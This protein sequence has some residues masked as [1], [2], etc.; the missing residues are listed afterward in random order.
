MTMKK[1]ILAFAL[2][3]VISLLQ[4]NMAFGIDWE[5]WRI[6]D[7]W[8]QDNFG[9]KRSP[10]DNTAYLEQQAAHAAA[11]AKKKQ[12]MKKQQQEA[13]K[14]QAMEQWK[15]LQKKLEKQV[16]EAEAQKKKR[17]QEVLKKIGGIGKGGKLEPFK[18]GTTAL[19]AQPIGTQEQVKFDATWMEK[20]KQLIEQRNS[21]V[22]DKY[23]SLKTKVPLRPLGIKE[24]LNELQAGDVLLIDAVGPQRAVSATDN[25]FSGGKE[26]TSSHTVSYLKEVNG[27]KLFMDNQPGAGPRIISEDEFLKEYG[28]RGIKAARLKEKP[29]ESKEVKQLFTAAVKMAQENRKE[30]VFIFTNYDVW[31]KGEV[32]SEA[33]RTL[34]L[35]AGRWTPS[36]LGWKEFL[37]IKQSP[38]DFY[39]RQYFEVI[40]LQ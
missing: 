29:L 14:K 37:G 18:W 40:P 31:G 32:C 8:T 6:Q 15:K 10:Q 13:K 9:V 36:S 1:G 34:L 26:S 7:W 38:A 28:H 27:K 3:F 17:G 2:C 16:V 19:V 21:Y 5:Q 24:K 39:N 25:F 23:K 33:S 30:T 20:Q 11:E 22:P 12:Q 35:K 4:A